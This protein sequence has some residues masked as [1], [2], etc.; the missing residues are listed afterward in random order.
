MGKKSIGKPQ[1]RLLHLPCGFSHNADWVGAENVR[2]RTLKQ[3]GLV[4]ASIYP[5]VGHTV[6]ACGGIGQKS[7]YEA[8][9]GRNEQSSTA[10]LGI[11]VL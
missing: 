9:T 4:D 3:L 1:G 6:E 5:A 7:P 10:P 8:G 2:Q 11:S